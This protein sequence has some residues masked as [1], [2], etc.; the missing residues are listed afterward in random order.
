MPLN[1]FSPSLIEHQARR[2]LERAGPVAAGWLVFG[3]SGLLFAAFAWASLA[4]I[5]EIVIAPGRVEPAGRVQT[6]NHP[7]GGLVQALHVND[8]QRVSKG[9]LL[10]TFAPEQAEFAKNEVE[11]SYQATMVTIARLQAELAGEDLT[12]VEPLKALAPGLVA[13]EQELQAARAAN[14]EGR[15]L[16]L[17]RKVEAQRNNARRAE[18][19]TNR[20][21]SNLRLLEQQ[22]AA[23]TEL[24]ERGL[25]PKLKLIE[26]QRQ[27]ND[28]AGELEKARAAQAASLSE[29]AQARG[30]LERL[31]KSW[32][33]AL[34]ADVSEAETRAAQ[35]AS[36]LAGQS[37]FLDGTVLRAP[38]DGIVQ[39]LTIT[40]D[41]QSVAA[42]A[43][44]M[45]LVP[46]GGGLV[47]KA[48]IANDDIGRVATDM[49]AAI[50]VHAYDFA[51]YGALD[52][53]V[54]RIAVDATAI[55][56]Q[57]LPTYSVTILT[58][59]PFLGGDPR[60]SV[61]PGMIV[62]VELKAGMRTL[63]SYL[64]DTLVTYREKAFR[65]G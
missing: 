33:E 30:E 57:S 17:S 6:I 16:A 21:V 64:T 8:G 63:I 38:A 39:D 1:D 7:Q 53:H 48:Q 50:K 19:D 20:I 9:D 35:L 54:E 60:N 10:V 44:L 13:R 28:M 22:V 56:P 4:E 31:D 32:R 3:I 41:G 2:D 14:Q 46:T 62:D 43:P 59:Q 34:V 51:R 18:S 12:L 42:N 25:Y 40:G 27:A 61:V 65:E 58:A 45:K 47:I 29:L 26:M 52:G 15:R 36:Q 49:L 5:E 11:T 37:T 23:I 55:D 24:T